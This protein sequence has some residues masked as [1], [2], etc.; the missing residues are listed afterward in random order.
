MSNLNDNLDKAKTFVEDTA[1]KARASETYNKVKDTANEVTQKIKDNETVA[2]AID[3]INQ[4]EYVKKVNKSKYSKLIKICAVAIALV[5]IYNLFFFIFGDKKAKKAQDFLISQIEL[6]AVN[7]NIDECNVE[8]KIIGKNE[9][10]SMYAFDTIVNA[11]Y[12]NQK[13]KTSSYI[14][15]YYDEENEFNSYTVGEYEYEKENKRDMKDIALA[16]LAKG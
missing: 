10:A 3:K 1:K 2:G 9:D 4:N 11:K 13:A 16:K 6:Q 7:E 5:V 15:I 12:M 8:A 14:V